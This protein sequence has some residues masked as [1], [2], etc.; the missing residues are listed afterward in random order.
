MNKETTLTTKTQT[1]TLNFSNCSSVAVV[2]WL[3]PVAE[4]NEDDFDYI[5]GYEA[6]LHPGSEFEV[7]VDGVMT[8]CIVP[9]TTT[10][11][12][13]LQLLTEPSEDCS[14]QENILRYSSFEVVL[15][16]GEKF[17]S[18]LIGWK[19]V[20]LGNLEL[21]LVPVSYDG[22]T[23]RLEFT[24]SDTKG[25]EYSNWVEGNFVYLSSFEELVEIAG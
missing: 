19:K 17:N 16:E 18:D 12:E 8:T 11:E 2:D 15:N 9:S 20:I 13:T 4:A 1:A 23:D 3:G 7:D 10:D 6:V 5:E 14:G 24:E 25:T 22:D 21:G